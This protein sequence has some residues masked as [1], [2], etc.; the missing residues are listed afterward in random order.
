MANL[1]NESK[2]NHLWDFRKGYKKLKKFIND[3][4]FYE[5]VKHIDFSCM[6]KVVTS[7][8][9]LIKMRLMFLVYIVLVIK[10]KLSEKKAERI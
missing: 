6:N 3:T 8:I 2:L 9:F 4:N 10:N 5:I 1:N 7:T